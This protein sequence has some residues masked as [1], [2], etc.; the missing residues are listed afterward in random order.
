[1]VR[2]VGAARDDDRVT[3]DPAVANLPRGRSTLSAAE[4]RRIALRA[5]GL[6]RR[7]PV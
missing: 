7:R 5:Q 4:A 1:L 3:D 6:D 2:S